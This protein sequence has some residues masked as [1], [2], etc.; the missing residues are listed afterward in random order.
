MQR[1]S[2]LS[3]FVVY[4]HP[5]P[6][7]HLIDYAASVVM[8]IACL[9]LSSYSLIR[10]LPSEWL[11]RVLSSKTIREQPYHVLGSAA[12]LWT[13]THLGVNLTGVNGIMYELPGND[14]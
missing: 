14:C 5:L 9:S 3:V 1:Q 2:N 7:W 8:L 4:A 13:Q 10:Y 12:A 6:R 11:T